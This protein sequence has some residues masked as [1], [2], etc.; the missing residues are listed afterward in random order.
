M[1]ARKSKKSVKKKSKIK[2]IISFMLFQIV[3][4]GITAPF[5]AYYGPFENVRNTLVT[6]AMTTLSHQWIAELFLS[7]ETINK[8]LKEQAVTNLS[9]K[10][11]AETEVTVNNKN[12]KT[13]ERFEVNSNKFTGYVLIVNDP[14]R[15]KVGYSE[16]LELEG[17]TTSE[18]AENN[19]AI[20]AIN[21]GGF[22][23]EATGSLWTGTGAKP[24][25]IIM[26]NGDPK[27][28]DLSSD[29]EQREV[30]AIT[31]DGVLLVGSYSLNELIQHK[32]KEAV[33]FGPALIVDGQKAITNGDG[34]WGIAPRTA[35]GQR[36]DGAI[37]LLVIDGRQTNSIGATLKEVQ[38]VLYEYGAHNASN[39]DGG[40]SS[41]MYYKGEVINSPSDSLGER[42]VPS[43]IYVEK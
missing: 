36:K 2:F 32:A 30:V 1:N 12:D 29:D 35:I 16:K 20:A 26:S 22:T 5:L 25:G 40:S 14:T 43:A 37:I 10:K 8:I 28:N 21:G 9:Q 31:E 39:L 6:T 24:T 15:V 34:G 18:I 27:Y 19:D 33:S 41:T 23:D 13:I 7:K 38:D 42:A 17:Q 4:T 11:D 3:F